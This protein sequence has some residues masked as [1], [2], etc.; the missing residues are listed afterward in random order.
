MSQAKKGLLDIELHCS[1]IKLLN[2]LHSRVVKPIALFRLQW[3]TR[4]LH[5]QEECPES[6]SREPKKA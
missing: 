5:G 3:H 1:M 2:Y 6:R 4:L